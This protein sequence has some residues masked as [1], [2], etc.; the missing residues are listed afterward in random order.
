MPTK[1]PALI[2]AIVGLAGVFGPPG[3]ASTDAKNGEATSRGDAEAT[4][5]VRG[6]GCPY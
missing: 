2:I 3:C 4:I 5:H 6:M 1:K